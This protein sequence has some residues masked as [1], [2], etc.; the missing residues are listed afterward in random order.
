MD[1]MEAIAAFAALGQPT[2]L[3]VLRLLI[4]TGPDG[5]AA[6]EIAAALDVRQNTLSTN[7]TILSQAGLIRGERHGRSIR[8]AV[9]MEGVRGLISFLLED[10]C[11][12][13]PELCRPL[14]DQ[15]ACAC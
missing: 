12:G 3:A 10:C 7:L 15:I 8:Y 11:K 4:Q 2:R 1:E 9:D 5:M 6:G 13:R 14:L